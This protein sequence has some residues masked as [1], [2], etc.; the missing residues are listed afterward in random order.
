MRVERRL[1]GGAVIYMEGDPDADATGGVGSLKRE[2][3]LALADVIH[4][5]YRPA[6]SL[7][8]PETEPEWPPQPEVALFAASEHAAP[9]DRFLN[10]LKDAMTKGKG[11]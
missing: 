6:P 4:E 9:E 5:F 10:R 2:S 3:W 8:P 1:K 11:T 7:A